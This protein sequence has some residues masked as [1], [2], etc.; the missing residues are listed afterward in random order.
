MCALC[1]AYVRHTNGPE[2]ALFTLYLHEFR[3]Y[4]KKKEG[5]N[6]PFDGG[7]GAPIHVSI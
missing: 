5:I 4:S 1:I 6:S 2:M 3:S 7:F